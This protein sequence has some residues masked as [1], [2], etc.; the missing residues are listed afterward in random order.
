MF[1][2]IIIISIKL[3]NHIK[4]FICSINI[5]DIIKQKIIIYYKKYYTYKIIEKKGN[6]YFCKI[7]F[8]RKFNLN[9]CLVYIQ[10][11]IFFFNKHAY[12]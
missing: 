4:Y 10:I 1:F 5:I 3:I 6:I 2:V 8:S 9:I 12:H 7:M 11:N